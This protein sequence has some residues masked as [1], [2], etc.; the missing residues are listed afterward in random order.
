MADDRARADLS[1][2]APPAAAGWR[3]SLLPF[4][5]VSVTYL[6]FTMTDGAV[7]MVVL[8][9]AFEQSF[10]ALEVAVMFSLYEFM[11]VVT[12]LLAGI[13]GSRWGIKATLLTGLGF[14]LAGLGMLFGWQDS[15]SK[16]E[17]IVFTTFAQML[18]GIAKDL[19]K[20]GGKTVAKLVTPTDKQNR[21]FKLV[22]LI[23][24]WKNSLK[25]VGYFLGAAFVSIS[26]FT[27]LGV[28]CGM[29]V[30]AIPWP[31]F[32]LKSDLGRVAKKNITLSAV[33]Q[34]NFNVS[35]LSLARAFLFGSRDLWFEVSL[36]MKCRLLSP[37]PFSISL[38]LY[39]SLSLSLS[40]AFSLSLFVCF[41]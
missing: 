32:A 19:T 38:S 33:F 3:E 25:G 12:N 11:G 40:L 37:P 34:K 14:Q 16:G 4:V 6:I 23:T 18:C 21:L 9:H 2:A 36:L 26:Y 8:L 20:L 30:A 1:A 39:L 7:R 31:L 24:G 5:V 10:S 41:Y 28:L 13:A 22:S 17:A 35:V 29:I 27:A 15:W